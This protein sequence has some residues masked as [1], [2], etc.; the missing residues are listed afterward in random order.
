MA[1]LLAFNAY[2]RVTELCELR[3]EDISEIPG[4]EKE[5]VLVS[6]KWSKTGNNQ[7]VSVDDPDVA[8]L[9]K[10]WIRYVSWQAGWSEIRATG[11]MWAGAWE[12]GGTLRGPLL[13]PGAVVFRRAFIETCTALGFNE[14]EVRFVRHSLRHGGATRDYTF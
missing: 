5:T 1:T 14:G 3:A 7:S 12:R 10:R 11:G 2:L 13:F 9:L 8:Y 4:L 6:L